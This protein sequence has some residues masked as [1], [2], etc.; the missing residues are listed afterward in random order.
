MS[1]RLTEAHRRMLEQPISS[2]SLPVRTINTL[3]N[4]S[5]AENSNGDVLQVVTIR[6][7]LSLTSNDLLAMPNLGETTLS[8]IYDALAEVGFLRGNKFVAVEHEPEDDDRARE[9]SEAA[10]LLNLGSFSPEE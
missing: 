10:K 6:D 3:E 4:A 2:L 7:L 9:Q 8:S 5:A 1:N